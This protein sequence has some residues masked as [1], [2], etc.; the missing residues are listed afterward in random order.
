MFGQPGKKLIFMGDEIAQPDEWRHDGSIDWDVL[1]QPPHAG[2]ERWLHDLNAAYRSMP[3]LH[4]LDCEP[5]GFEWIDANDAA[6]S[7]LTFLR[8]DSERRPVAVALNFTPVLRAHYRIGVPGGGQWREIL[9]SDAREYGGSGQR[10]EGTIDAS[11][12]A[13][14]GRPYSLSITLPPLGAVFLAPSGDG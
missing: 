10:N 5:A 1:Q 2:V 14:H 7:V 4:E 6:N 9:N 11:S 3:A 12:V 13:W 8:M